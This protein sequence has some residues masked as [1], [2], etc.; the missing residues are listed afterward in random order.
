M[1]K[2][3]V[4]AAVLL[5]QVSFSQKVTDSVVIKMDTTTY[6]YITSLIRENID[7]RSATGQT[8][9]GNI[10]QPLSRFSFLQPADKPKEI[11]V[12]Q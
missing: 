1:K 10:L 3:L 4:I 11:K 9:L 7:G 6:K 2:V 5:S 12:K 8:I